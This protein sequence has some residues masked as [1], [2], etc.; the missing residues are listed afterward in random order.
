MWDTI[1]DTLKDAFSWLVDWLK[2]IALDLV[3]PVIEGVGALIPD[4]WNDGLTTA[5][6]WANYL[7]TWIPVTLAVELFLA[8]YA[9]K[10]TLVAVKYV[11]KAIPTIW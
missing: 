5:I 11:L 10:A 9:I 6:T 7:N 3:M 2:S 4:S 1:L 8:Y